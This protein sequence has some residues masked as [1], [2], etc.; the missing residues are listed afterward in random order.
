M[1]TSAILNWGVLDNDSTIT[2]ANIRQPEDEWMA[3]SFDAPGNQEAVLR[4]GRD[5]VLRD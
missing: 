1:R 5:L 4:R 2:E 3:A